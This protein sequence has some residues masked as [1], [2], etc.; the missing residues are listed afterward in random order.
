[1][2]SDEVKAN[3]KKFELVLYVPAKQRSK[4]QIFS[5]DLNFRLRVGDFGLADLQI[6]VFVK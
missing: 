5:Q 3:K 2:K 4:F 1:M 6:E